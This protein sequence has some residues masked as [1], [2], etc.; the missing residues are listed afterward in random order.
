MSDTG[1]A[2]G[3]SMAQVIPALPAALAGIPAGIGLYAVVSHGAPM[4]VPPMT[5]PPMTWLIAEVLGT[6]LA[7]A[8]LTAISARI[9]AR[10]SVAEILQL[11]AA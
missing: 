6:L 4:S 5:V 8:G 3:L 11:E 9:G 10:H 2:A 1:S 7:V